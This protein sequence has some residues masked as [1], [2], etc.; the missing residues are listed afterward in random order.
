MHKVLLFEEYNMI[1]NGSSFDSLGS[2]ETGVKH[3]F[4]HIH[5]LV[6]LPNTRDILIGKRLTETVQP[7]PRV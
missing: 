6:V 5:T 7:S 1:C 4:L 3:I 2:L